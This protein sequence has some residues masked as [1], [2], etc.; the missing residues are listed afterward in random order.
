[1]V[2]KNTYEFDKLNH[3]VYSIQ[4]HLIMVVKYRR[5]VFDNNEI[6]DRLKQLTK[7]IAENFGCDIVN[8]ECDIDHIHIIFKATPKVELTKLINSLKGSTSKTLRHEFSNLKEKLWGDSFWNN[9]YCLVSTG[10]VTLDQLKKYVE[11]QKGKTK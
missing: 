7:N 11:N 5:K 10:Q 9:S 8:Q 2:T 1:M 3:S 6:I 4:F